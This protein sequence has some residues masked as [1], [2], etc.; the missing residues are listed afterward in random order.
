MV[1]IQQET[2]PTIDHFGYVAIV[3]KPNVGKSTLFNRLL[4]KRLSI[5][6][7][8]AQ[9]TLDRIMG[10][11]SDTPYQYVMFDTPGVKSRLK[12]RHHAHLNRIAQQASQE[13][14]VALFM[15][16][17]GQIEEDD[18]QA[19]SVLESFEGPVIAVINKIDRHKG[20]GLHILHEAAEKLK[21]LYDF[22]AIMGI[23]CKTEENI[24]VLKQAIY[25]HLPEMDGLFEQDELT[26]HTDEFIACEILRQMMLENVHEEVPY[27]A[28][29]T[30]EKFEREEKIDHIHAIFWVKHPSQKPLVIGQNGQMIKRIGTQARLAMQSHFNRKVFLKTWVKVG[31]P[32]DE[33]LSLA[34]DV[35]WEK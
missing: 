7:R 32:N 2:A 34:S 10:V 14:D 29:I 5:V 1:K 25:G 35:D 27:T 21:T 17:G 24:D 13:A 11:V 31:T 3:G 22:E 15:I 16:S 8:K 12:H 33:D 9:T 19:L 28:Q 18:L 20:K 23:S 30:I 4:G 6:T 26:Q